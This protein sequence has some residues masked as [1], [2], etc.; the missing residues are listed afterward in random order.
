MSARSSKKRRSPRQNQRCLRQSFSVFLFVEIVHLT[1]KLSSVSHFLSR[2]TWSHH[3]ARCQKWFQHE[4]FHW[5]KAKVMMVVTK[6]KKAITKAAICIQQ[7]TQ[8]TV[9]FSRH[10]DISKTTWEMLQ[11]ARTGGL[12][13]RVWKWRILKTLISQLTF[14]NQGRWRRRLRLLHNINERFKVIKIEI[15]TKCGSLSQRTKLTVT[16]YYP[17]SRRRHYSSLN[18]TPTFKILKKYVQVELDRKERKVNSVPPSTHYQNQTLRV[19]NA[20]NN[21]NIATMCPQIY[22]DFKSQLRKSAVNSK[23]GEDQHRG[24]QAYL[25]E[26]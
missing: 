7:I 2:L 14:K 8:N 18:F 6:F 20:N 10:K 11:A 4:D 26:R 24:K 5:A 13:I 15:F 12:I 9:I 1:K 21:I 19:H 25:D 16:G 17:K 22:I 23:T 3:C